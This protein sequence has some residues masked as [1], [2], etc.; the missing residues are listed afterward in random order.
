VIQPITRSQTAEVVA[1]TRDYITFAERQLAREFPLIPVHFDL[2]GRSAGM[3]VVR[4]EHCWI[5]Y[6]PWIFGKYYRENLEGTVPHEVA[7]YIV[8]RLYRGRR[9]KPHGAQW[10]QVMQLFGADPEVT[11]NLDL[12]GIPQRR[13]R[14]HS[15]Y[16][17]CREH[18]L[19]TTRHNRARRG[20]GRYQCRHCRQ[21]LVYRGD[22]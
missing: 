5:R 16:C 21:L 15:Y 20:E 2:S 4:G 19:S 13:Q 9:V 12:A 8:H 17:G 22:Q 3:F 14:T 11:F 1:A 7:H 18:A 10:R 6:N